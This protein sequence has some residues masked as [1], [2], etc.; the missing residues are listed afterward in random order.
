MIY[1]IDE[2][3]MAQLG[4]IGTIAPELAKQQMSK[5]GE[6]VKEAMRN[7]MTKQRHNW[8]NRVVNGRYSPYK[9]RTKQKELGRRT[10]PDGKEIEPASMSNFI[11]NY[12]D[13]KNSLL[14]V[15]GNH[16]TFRAVLRENGMIV[17]KAKEPV[18]G[19]TLTLKA[20]IMKM[21]T[22]KMGKNYGWF[23][24]GKFGKE[25]MIANPK[26]R[27]WN[28]MGQGVADSRSEF[29]NLITTEYQRLFKKVVMDTKIPMERVS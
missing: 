8:F 5:G 12:F 24:N 16:P 23:R 1:E 6:V 13:E 26:F 17:G 20:I 28:F 4:A 7:N 29:N 14:V 11:N 15:G 2:N 21:E 3:F 18:K 27:K 22:G 10:T 19:V 9:S 25:S